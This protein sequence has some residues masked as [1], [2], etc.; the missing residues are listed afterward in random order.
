MPRA[1]AE[2]CLAYRTSQVHGGLYGHAAFSPGSCA[3]RTPERC[4]SVPDK[5]AGQ[6]RCAV[7]Y[8]G[9]TS[10]PFTPFRA[11][12][13]T[14]SARR[15]GCQAPRAAISAGGRRRRRR[16]AGVALGPGGMAHLLPRALA[17]F[18]ARVTPL[19]RNVACSWGKPHS[20]APHFQVQR[21]AVC[22]LRTP[23]PSESRA[24]RPASASR[25]RRCG[26]GA[27]PQPS[28]PLPT[29]TAGTPRSS[30]SGCPSVTAHP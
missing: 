24:W 25:P 20:A 28:V 15:R 4:T 5:R 26:T 2:R 10:T 8:L 7:K 11:G 13:T 22:G 29:M 21:W 3:L 18:E 17:A 30:K 6:K 1:A 23:C 9:L 19:Q 27:S 16:K 14:T 12:H